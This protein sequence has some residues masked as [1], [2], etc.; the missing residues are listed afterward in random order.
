MFTS[1]SVFVFLIQGGRVFRI[2]AHE[3]EIGYSLKQNRV[4][5]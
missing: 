2:I 1:L 5:N 3:Y 4:N